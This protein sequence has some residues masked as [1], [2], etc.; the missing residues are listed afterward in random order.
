MGIGPLQEPLAQAG[1]NFS[2]ARTQIFY[3]FS[4]NSLEWSWEF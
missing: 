3:K 2:R 4:R 1:W